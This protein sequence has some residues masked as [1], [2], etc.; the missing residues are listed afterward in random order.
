M[1]VELTN[2]MTV[3]S[4]NLNHSG[5]LANSEGRY[6]LSFDQVSVELYQS[7]GWVIAE[8]DLQLEVTLGLN[9]QQ[10][11]ALEKVMQQ[12]L[13]NVRNH[14]S[15]IAINGQGKLTLVQRVRQDVSTDLFISMVNNQVDIAEK[16][17]QLM[18][19][20]TLVGSNLNHVWLP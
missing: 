1:N 19:L 14:N 16:Y 2:L 4:T 6:R 7:H 12:A 18:Q 5:F 8:S 10:E 11:M 15:I 17:Q 3:L 13:I 20:H 9:Y